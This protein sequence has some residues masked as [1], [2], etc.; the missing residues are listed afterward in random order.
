M[1]YNIE[2]GWL[3]ARYVKDLATVEEIAA[4]VGCTVANIKRLLKKWHIR[5]GKA[6]QQLGIIPA[7]NK[8][9][10]KETDDRLM[11]I[12]QAHSG[13]GNPM[14]GRKAWNSGLTKD[15]DPRIAAIASA[16]SGREVSEET[17][18]RMSEAKI[19]LRGETANNWRGGQSYSG[20]YGVFRYTVGGARNYA[21]RHV[22]SEA[23]G[24]PL[25]KD[26]HVHHIDRNKTNNQPEN[27]I[28][29]SEPDHNRLH[30]AIEAGRETPEQQRAWLNACGIKY[31]EVKRED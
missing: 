17:R 31:L 20:G 11:A 29:I 15:D 2:R 24:R 19:G 6:L 8:G 7:W 4:E 18:A 21:H 30:R 3:E 25:T 1:R 22:A 12:S 5:R 23:L 14:A 13:D 9:L 16:I 26:E 28:V 10:T 27:L